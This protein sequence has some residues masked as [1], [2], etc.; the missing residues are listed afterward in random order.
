MAMAQ[1]FG[2]LKT[3]VVSAAACPGGLANPVGRLSRGG[4]GGRTWTLVTMD[5]TKDGQFCQEALSL[6]SRFKTKTQRGQPKW[7]PLNSHLLGSS[8]RS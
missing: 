4:L 1:Y 5:L 3:K 7:V 8:Q 2:V 6:P